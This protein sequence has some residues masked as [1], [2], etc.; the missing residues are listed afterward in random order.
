MQTIVEAGSD[1]QRSR[2]VEPVLRGDAS[3]CQLFSEPNAGSD[4]AAVRTS[5]RRVGGGWRVTGQKVWT[6]R[7]RQCRWGLATVRTDAAAPKHAGVTMMA[8]DLSA[9]GVQVRPLRELTGGAMFNEVFLDDVFVPDADVVGDVGQGW[10]VA[11]A[12]L[13]NERISIGGGSGAIDLG[14]DDLVKLLDNASG[15]SAAGWVGRV[16]RVIAE[17]HTLRPLNTRIA[18]GALVG[19]EAGSAANVIKLVKAECS[20]RITELAMELAG[21]DAVTSRSPKLTQDYL[22]A[23]CLTIAGGTSE[24]MRNTIAERLLGLPRD[25]LLS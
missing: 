16:G 6:S 19:A 25:P 12:T 20:Q 23:R 24:I 13:G 17:W 15:A 22:F 21:I 7:A 14:P 1:D 8:I 4:A 9:Q 5:A 3:W 11:R 2:W 10:R 18:A